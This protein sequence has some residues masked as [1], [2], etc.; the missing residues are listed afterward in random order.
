[1]HGIVAYRSTFLRPDVCEKI[2]SFLLFY[3]EM[4]AKENRFLFSAS[5]F[6]KIYFLV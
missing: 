3:K 6:I 4:H 5:R 1:M 2:T